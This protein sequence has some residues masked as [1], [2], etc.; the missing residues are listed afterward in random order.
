MNHFYKS[1]VVFESLGE[2]KEYDEILQSSWKTWKLKFDR[3]KAANHLFHN[4]K[5]LPKETARIL[6]VCRGVDI[7]VYAYPDHE[8]NAFVIPGFYIG[9][10]DDKWPMIKKMDQMYRKNWVVR[11]FW[12]LLMATQVE[13]VLAMKKYTIN[14][15]NR[16]V[17][18]LDKNIS[19]VSIFVTYG[20]LTFATPEQRL[21][22]Y[23]HELG[24]WVDAAKHIPFHMERHLN[25]ERIFW[26]STQLIQRYVTR[27]SELEADKFAKDVG[28]G[29]ELSSALGSFGEF[30]TDGMSWIVKFHKKAVKNAIETH[31]D[32]ED[33]GALDVTHYPSTKQRQKYLQDNDE[34]TGTEQK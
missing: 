24:H 28:Y 11:N 21:G 34:E 16:T 17:T 22:V 18:F 5:E 10:I 23:L 29:P 8:M 7:K 1:N 14:K 15:S 25:H 26:A 4:L 3:E 27:Y 2:Y 13:S 19:R 12:E 6:K 33:R 9:V 20:M 31:N 30:N 32:Y